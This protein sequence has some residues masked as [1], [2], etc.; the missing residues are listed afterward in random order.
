V[1]E[2]VL[3]ETYGVITYQEQIMRVLNK[4]GGIELS[5]SYAV[6]KAISKKIPEK[7]ESGRADWMKG[8]AERGVST[9][10]AEDI[11]AKIVFF[12]G[13]GFNKSHTAAYA[14]IGYQTAYLKTHFTAEFMAALLSSEIDEG[15]KRELMVDHIAD[16]RKLGVEVECP[17][18]NKGQPDFD[19]VN[20][21][22]VFG[23]TA[24]KGL[25]RGAAEE[26]VKARERG[27]P[28]R[29][30]FDFSA[31]VDLRVVK[32]AQIE[33]VI[34]AG[35]M[36]CFSKN[37]NALLHTLPRAIASAEAK[38]EDRR[39]GQKNMFD[40]VDG[41]EGDDVP[42]AGGLP[43]DEALSDVPA[44]SDLDTL[45]FEKEVLD[46]YMSSHPLAQY[47]EQ[48]R[49]FRSH[50]AVQCA[51][52]NAGTEVRLAGMVVELIPKL[53][54]KG[55]NAGNRWAIVR[56][57][58][59]SGA[60][61]CIMWSDQFQRFGD[62][63]KADAILL[64]DGKVEWREGSGEPDVIVERVM[65]MEQARADLTRGLVLRMK[66]RTD[67]DGRQ[68]FESVGKILKKA[69]GPCPVYLAVQDG[70][71]RAAQFKLSA[72]FFVNPTQVPVEQLE[73]ILGPGAVLFTGR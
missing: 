65:T 36:D 1:L 23:L 63:V 43:N 37:R 71:G 33:K 52:M 25:G 50:D 48:L 51:K 27:G 55:R 31:R 64:F 21:K 8:C 15:N 66:Y 19:V 70:A 38:Q 5:K 6:I 49:R 45:K 44:W 14:Q 4:L 72:D 39:R 54:S 58:D 24:I 68:A 41:G 57:E 60:V 28:Y 13:Y 61:K 32:A 67:D 42:V 35:A 30:I 40:L 26:I 16:A 34:K 10:V 22:I 2:E 46:F 47:D 7:I 12:A 18:V 3:A 59:F 62:L 29:G 53:V 69:K 56:I 11:F 17:N 9:E 20:G 73:M